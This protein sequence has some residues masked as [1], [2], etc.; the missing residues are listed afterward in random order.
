MLYTG[1]Y[2]MED[3][4]HL[5]AAE[6]PSTSP[7]V[8][9]V[10]STYGVQ[11]RTVTT[12]FFVLGRG[13]IPPLLLFFPSRPCLPACLPTRDVPAFSTAFLARGL[14]VSCLS[15]Q[16]APRPSSG[17]KDSPNFAAEHGDG[18]TRSPPPLLSEASGL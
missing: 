14:P 7:D 13:I 17:Q 4:R 2:S 10:E 8:L 11:A 6:M 3:D 18:S 15:R 9:I 16:H 5:M 12:C 1:D